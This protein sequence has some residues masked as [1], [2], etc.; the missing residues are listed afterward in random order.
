LSSIAVLA[1]GIG[2]LAG[3][4]QADH[5]AGLIVGL[6][7]IVAGGRTLF[8]VLHEITEGGVSQD[9]M[10]KIESAI[11]AVEGMREWHYLRT[12][13]VG[14]ETFIDLHVLVDPELSIV[15]AH[16]ISTEIEGTLRSACNRPAN[17]TVHVEPD[18]EEQR[19][20]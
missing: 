8:V 7:V 14:R 17:V 11:E 20:R 19:R 6:M 13:R 4:G 1:G 2:G 10:A 18:L 5:F 3:W 15:D 16:R 12:R 9:E